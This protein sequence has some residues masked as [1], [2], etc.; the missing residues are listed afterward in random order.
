MAAIRTSSPSL[1]GETELTAKPTAVTAVVSASRTPRAD[2][3]RIS[4]QRQA[5]TRMNAA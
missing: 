3:S 5:R 4:C 2:A 1:K